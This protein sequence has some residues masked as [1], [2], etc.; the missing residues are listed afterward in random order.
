MNFAIF[1]VLNVSL[2]FHPMPKQT[3]N[4]VHKITTV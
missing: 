4:A 1:T 3:H 2:C